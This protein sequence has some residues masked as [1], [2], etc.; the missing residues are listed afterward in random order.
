MGWEQGRYYTR[1]VKRQGRVYREYYGCSP[2]AHL[3]ASE[4]A[5]QRLARLA[6]TKARQTLV[7]DLHN[8][9]KDM[10]KLCKEVEDITS[11]ALHLAGYHLDCKTWK[12]RKKNG[13]RKKS[14]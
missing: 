3:I 4:H 10:T 11:D 9:Q 13:T 2:A 1:S 12:W 14:H 6:E 8:E 7:R 5:R